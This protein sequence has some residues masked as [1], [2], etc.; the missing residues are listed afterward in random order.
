VN[1]LL[2]SQIPD[3]YALNS[4]T[5]EKNTIYLGY[6]PSSLTINATANGGTAPYTYAWSTGAATQSTS[7]SAAGTYTVTITDAKGCQTTSSIVINVLDVRCGNN[8]DKVMVCHNGQTICVASS[9]VQAHLDHG[10]QLGSC[11]TGTISSIPV[12]LNLEKPAT[13]KVVLYPNPASDI[14]N[15]QVSKL[16]AGATLRVFNLGGVEVLSQRLTQTLQTISVSKLQPGVYVVQITN[17]TQLTRE[18]VIKE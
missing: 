15:I 14:L 10:D 13:Y 12:S 1:Y 9:A 18:K 8:N 17:G 5:D 2:S 6:G 16:E 11:N 7:V 3:V 4:Y